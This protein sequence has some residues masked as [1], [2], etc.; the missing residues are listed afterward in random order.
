MSYATRIFLP[1]RPRRD[2]RDLVGWCSPGA[3]TT[4]RPGTDRDGE[5]TSLTI[6]PALGVVGGG[7]L[8]GI[9]LQLGSGS[10]RV[11]RYAR[12]SWCGGSEWAGVRERRCCI[13]L[14]SARA[15]GPGDTRN[16][17][18][19]ELALGDV[20]FVVPVWRRRRP[21]LVAK[22][23][24]DSR[25]GTWSPAPCAGSSRLAATIRR[26]RRYRRSY[27]LLFEQCRVCVHVRESLRCGSMV[28][29]WHLPPHAV[30]FA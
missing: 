16:V 23:H 12:V 10:I 3:S 5:T 19:H 7:R 21:R 28:R 17:I 25:R 30:H 13:A 2:A 29:T 22:S 6:N 20:R 1:A 27:Q 11:R 18:R 24:L 9:L 14:T 15:S 4:R 8:F 26:G